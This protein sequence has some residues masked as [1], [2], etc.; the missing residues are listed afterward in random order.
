M[1]NL[2]AVEVA[3]QSA[4]ARPQSEE[5]CL[6]VSLE[7]VDLV[8]ITLCTQPSLPLGSKLVVDDGLCLPIGHRVAELLHFAACFG[9]SISFFVPHDPT[10]RRNP[11]E[12]Y[13]RLF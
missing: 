12:R 13:D 9:E 1:G 7:L 3:Q 5:N 10:V 6:L 2:Q 4:V 11:L 8:S